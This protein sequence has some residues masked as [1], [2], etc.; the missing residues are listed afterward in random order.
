MSDAETKVIV[1]K[2]VE[3]IDKPGTEWVGFNI[4]VGTQYPVKLSTKVEKVIEEARAVGGETA[5]WTFRESDGNENPNK[6]GTFY[7]NRWLNKVE[8]GTHA[9]PA[10]SPHQGAP[11]QTTLPVETTTEPVDWDAKER[12]DYRSR[13]WAITVSA[14]TH[15]IKPDEDPVEVFKRLLPFQLRLYHDVVRELGVPDDVNIPF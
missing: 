2:C 9:T 15:T 14:F 13:T 5:T 4:D 10:S 12:R 1:G 3:I 11:Q 6:P 8:A 7:K